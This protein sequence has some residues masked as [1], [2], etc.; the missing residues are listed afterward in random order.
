MTLWMLKSRLS[1]LNSDVSTLQDTR[2]LTFKATAQLFIL[3]CTWCLGILQVREQYGK[4][5]KRVRKPKAESETFTLSSRAMSDASKPIT[6][7]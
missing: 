5:F 6:V 2:M 7:N 1:S 4:W 3:G